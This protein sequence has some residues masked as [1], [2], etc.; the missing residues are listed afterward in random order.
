MPFALKNTDCSPLVVDNEFEIVD[1]NLLASHVGELLL[2]N[3]LHMMN[4][5]NR[6]S[7][8][9]P[10]TP[11][12]II[13]HIVSAVKD[14]SIEK[15][16]GW[17]FQMI[18]WLVLVTKYTGENFHA[19]QPHGAPAHHGIDGLGI[20]LKADNTIDKIVV[21]EDKFTDNPRNLI[22]RQIWPEFVSFEK[23]EKDHVLVGTLST[24][25]K[26]L[27]AGKVFQQIQND[28][29]NRDLRLYRV[30]INRLE[31]HN[32]EEGRKRLFADYRICVTGDLPRR[33][34]ATVYIEEHREWMANF[35]SLVIAYLNN[36]KK[37]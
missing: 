36:K 34:G 37:N 7:S 6:L 25:L 23:S 20:L 1:E 10:E 24:M 15:R 19:Q 33:S 5:I 9:A 21:C 11:N 22:Q 16:D 3:H 32:P 12:R 28:I 29:F 17:L 30:G 8:V 31:T 2:G 26:N 14:S 35:A 18:S 27:D 4:V 13:D